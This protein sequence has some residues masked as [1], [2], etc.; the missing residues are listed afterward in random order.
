[1]IAPLAAL[2][3]TAQPAAAG[4]MPTRTP[5]VAPALLTVTGAASPLTLD[6]AAMA[7]LPHTTATVA[8]HGKTRTF[9]GVPVATILAKVGAPTGEALR[10]K[11]LLGV[12]VA[13]G[14][15][16]YRVALSLAEVDP[17][18]KDAKTI[19]ADA[20]DGHPLS[21][22]DGPFKLVVEGDKRPA[23]AVHGLVG[24]ELTQLP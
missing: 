21:A 3:L 23:R 15:D 4:A 14:A 13:S 10:G 11:R 20:E 18:V 7:A 1:M 24:L 17:G 22:K 12:V 16:G 19:V 9:S 2:L 6:A 5:V 8:D